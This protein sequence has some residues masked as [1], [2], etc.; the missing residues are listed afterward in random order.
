LIRSFTVN[1]YPPAWGF[2]WSAEVA[3]VKEAVDEMALEALER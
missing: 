1:T 2:A 3:V